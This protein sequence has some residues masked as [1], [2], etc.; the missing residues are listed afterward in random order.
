[1]GIDY[2]GI[3][4]KTLFLA[5][6][7]AVDGKHI[8]VIKPERG[9]SDYLILQ[10]FFPPMELVTDYRFVYVDIGI[11]G[12]DWD[13]TIFKRSAVC[14]TDIIIVW[15][16]S[17]LWVFAFSARSLQVLQSLPVSFQFFIFSLF[18]SSMT[19]RADIPCCNIE[20]LSLHLFMLH[21]SFS[22][23]PTGCT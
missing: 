5:C 12:K 10:R 19:Y 2:F 22:I 20:F 1:M 15:H 3:L 17:P 8:R 14:S 6:L 4:E 21:G 13:S 11:Y 18:K 7:G 16:Y 23:Y 9:G